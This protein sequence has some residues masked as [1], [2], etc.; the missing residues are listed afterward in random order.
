MK[1]TSF[2]ALALLA[3]T[4][5]A[6]DISFS[7]PHFGTTWKLHSG[8]IGKNSFD[9]SWKS[10]CDD[11]DNSIYNIELYIMINGQQTLFGAP[12]IGK[13]DCSKKEGSTKVVIPNILSLPTSDKYSISVVKD[14]IHSYSDVFIINNPENRGK[15]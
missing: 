10:G 6:A 13:L 3:S 9:V 12:P 7:E 1:I 14:G 4:T 8:R 15:I 11:N 5:I 2:I